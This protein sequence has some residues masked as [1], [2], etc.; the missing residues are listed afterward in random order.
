MSRIF[1]GSIVPENERFQITDY[2]RLSAL[3]YHAKRWRK[4]ENNKLYK[5]LFPNRHEAREARFELENRNADR[6]LE[7]KNNPE[8]IVVRGT[9][10]PSGVFS[11]FTGNP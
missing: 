10:T 6:W 5:F 4:V 11:S 1:G 7:H 8:T 3:T 2:P 9:I